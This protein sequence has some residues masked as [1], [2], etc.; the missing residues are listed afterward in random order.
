MIY[1]YARVST[2]NQN[3]DAQISAL[4]KYGCDRIFAEKVTGRASKKKQREQFELMNSLLQADDTVVV[5]KLDRLSRTLIDIINTL[6]HFDNNNIH[7][8]SI[9]DNF[10]TKTPYGKAMLH[11]A[12]VFSQ[13]ELELISER[14]IE[15]L[16]EARKHGRIGGKRPT[17]R[18]IIKKAYKMYKDGKY[19]VSRI[20]KECGI[21]KT[22]MYKYIKICEENPEKYADII[23]SDVDIPSSISPKIERKLG[24][25]PISDTTINNIKLL[26][27][28]SDYSLTEISKILNISYSTV[29]K[30]CKLF[31]EKRK[32]IE[33][34]EREEQKK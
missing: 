9:T 27:Y 16:I 7:F 20:C 29:S 33:K 25:L 6:E 8:V 34:D 3:L 19:A 1:G 28:K 12:A 5:W 21:S 26:Y 11:I 17:D 2:K 22:T 4:Q 31:E 32:R 18:E 14:T 23:Y 10:N 15:G 24:R 13:L 30:Y